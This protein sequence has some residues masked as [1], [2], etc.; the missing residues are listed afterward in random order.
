MADR[1]M[2]II[3]IDTQNYLFCRLQLVVEKFGLGYLKHNLSPKSCEANEQEIDILGTIIKNSSM[4]PP[5]LPICIVAALLKTKDCK[6]KSFC[7]ESLSLTFHT[8]H[9]P[10]INYI[11]FYFLLRVFKHLENSLSNP[12]YLA[13]NISLVCRS[14]HLNIMKNF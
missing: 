5:S 11:E 12:P 6:K 2:Y 9:D 3:N 7:C 14:S 13:H 4:S 1:F 8:T 10:K